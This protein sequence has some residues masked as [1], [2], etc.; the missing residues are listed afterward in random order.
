MIFSSIRDLLARQWTRL[1]ALEQALLTWLAIVREPCDETDLHAMLVPPLTVGQVHEALE[2][3]HRRSLVERGQQRV[4]FTLQSVVLEYVT[5]V[6][7]E[8][9]NEQI[10][11]AVWE[12]LIGYA[13]EQAGSKEYVRQA[14]ERL[15]VAP[16]LL[17]LQAISRGQMCVR[18]CS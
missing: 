12:Y 11:H 10:Q 15:I 8:R 14:Q 4:T 9:V 7:V 5:E 3:L 13:L 2:A 16:I 6:L 18:S 1:T 17:R